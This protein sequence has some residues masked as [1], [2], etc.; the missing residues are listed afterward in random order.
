[1]R[2]RFVDR[3]VD[4]NNGGKIYCQYTW[5]EDLELYRDH[6]PN[7]HVVP[8]VLLTEMMGQSASL[9]LQSL[10][11]DFGT[12]MLIQ[13]TNAKFRNWVRPGDMLDTYAE[14]LSAQVKLARVKIK[15]E[16]NDSLIASAELLFTFEANDKLGLPAVDPV[17]ADYLLSG[18]IE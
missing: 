4:L 13:I 1:M 11:T 6:F 16:N 14:V 15:T 12:P 5:P 18:A 8:G 10:Y 9:C 7:F 3:I 17:L 2:Y